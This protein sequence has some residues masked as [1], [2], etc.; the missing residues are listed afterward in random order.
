M[1]NRSNRL[2]GT[3]CPVGRRLKQE[4]VTGKKAGEA[5]GKSTRD[6]LKCQWE[7]SRALQYITGDMEL[8]VGKIGGLIW[9][10]S[11]KGG[12]DECGNICWFSIL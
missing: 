6:E 12:F 2:R 9:E 10:H 11:F 4:K 1:S 8:E 7:T 3:L 5:A